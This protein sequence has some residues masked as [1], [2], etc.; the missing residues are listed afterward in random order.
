[1]CRNEAIKRQVEMCREG[2]ATE[3][4]R[5]RLTRTRHCCKRDRRFVV[6]Q[7]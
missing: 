1:V 2:L 5:T 6:I 3:T 4:E 7:R